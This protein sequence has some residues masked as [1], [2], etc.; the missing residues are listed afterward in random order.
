MLSKISVSSTHRATLEIWLHLYPKMTNLKKIGWI[1][2]GSFIGLIP[3]DLNAL[4]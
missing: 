1:E 4:R 3:K 2:V